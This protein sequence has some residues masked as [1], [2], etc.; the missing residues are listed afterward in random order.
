MRE[1]SEL[2]VCVYKQYNHI[3]EDGIRKYAAGV[4]TWLLFA[5]ESKTASISSEDMDGDCS[6]ISSEDADGD[7]SSFNGTQLSHMSPMGEYDLHRPG[8]IGNG[9]N[10]SYQ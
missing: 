5:S 4:L 1:P 7:Q 6:S 9:N 10:K 3:N 2:S 8:P